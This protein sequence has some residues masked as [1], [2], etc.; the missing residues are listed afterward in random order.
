VR[1][2]QYASDSLATTPTS[3]YQIQTIG[4]YSS[5]HVAPPPGIQAYLNT[6]D[7]QSALPASAFVPQST[8][9]DSLQIY[10]QLETLGVR[11]LH[12]PIYYDPTGKLY[13]TSAGLKIANQS[14]NLTSVNPAWGYPGWKIMNEP[15]FDFNTTCVTLTTCLFNIKNWLLTTPNTLPIVV[16]LEP[17]NYTYTSDNAT[18]AAALAASNQTEAPDTLAQPLSIETTNFSAFQPWRDLENEILGVFDRNSYQIVVTPEDLMDDENTLSS[19]VVKDGNT[20]YPS[21]SGLKSRVLFVLAGNSTANYLEYY[22]DLVNATMF[23][24]EPYNEA[25]NYST[26]TIF[27]DVVGPL[28]GV[29]YT[30][31]SASALS[32]AA[33]AQAAKVSKA[34]KAGFLV[35]ASADWNTWEP[36]NNYTTR[37]QKILNAGAHFVE[38]T[39]PTTPTLFTSTYTVAL[40]IRGN[41]QQSARC[42]PVTSG[43]VVFNA[44]A[45]YTT[46]CP[47]VNALTPSLAPSA[48]SS[49]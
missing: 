45:L 32:T 8:Q 18:F 33:D 25:G 34:V 38:T 49:A 15:N 10:N 1:T 40:P 37:A 24:S 41:V 36:R 5:A 21:L 12:F 9:Y 39:F 23:I 44:T 47:R 46:G 22:P 28:E 29:D 31:F 16:Y 30:N 19:S 11:Q 26:S 14:S 42:N 48:S 43:G 17:T 4:T 35:R 20:L 3:L 6:S 7:A 2:G 27:V 13:Q